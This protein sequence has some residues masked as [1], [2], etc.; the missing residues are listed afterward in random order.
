MRLMTGKIS[1]NAIRMTILV[2]LFQL[3]S[4]AA[5]AFI[6]DSKQNGHYSIICTTQGYQQV[7][8]AQDNKQE[9]SDTSSCPVC[10]LTLGAL[11]VISSNT[12][13]LVSLTSGGV[14]H[15][16]TI[17]DN[18]QLNNLSKSFAIRAPPLFS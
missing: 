13:Q 15:I 5:S 1:L 12:E 2:M 16:L 11:D 9:R 10:L 3:L 8:I 7:W 18:T 14:T 17:Q 6:S 4:P